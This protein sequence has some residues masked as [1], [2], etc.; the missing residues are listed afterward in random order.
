M[1][2]APP[3]SRL[4]AL[5]EPPWARA[6][7]A[8]R[9]RPRPSEVRCSPG[10]PRT[11]GWKTL[12][13]QLGGE[14]GAAIEDLEDDEARAA[15][16]PQPVEPAAVFA[17]VVAAGWPAPGRPGWDRRRRGRSPLADQLVGGQARALEGAGGDVDGVE[18]AGDQGLEL[19]AGGGQQLAHQPVHLQQLALELVP[20]RRR[21]AAVA[22]DV[23]QHPEAG[24]GRAQLVRDGGQQLALVGDLPLDPRRPCR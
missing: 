1:S 16:D 3:P 13:E 22:G 5:T 15:A 6:M 21:G 9:A 4:A 24:Q 8:T 2:W 20:G 14:A 17:G 7:R 12:L 10:L 19:E 23:Q 11:N 18:R